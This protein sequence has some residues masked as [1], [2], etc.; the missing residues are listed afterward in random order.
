MEADSLDDAADGLTGGY[1]RVL[2]H[3]ASQQSGILIYKNIFT[4]FALHDVHAVLYP[5]IVLYTMLHTTWVLMY[6]VFMHCVF[7]NIF[8][9][10]VFQKI[11]NFLG[12]YQP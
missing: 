5:T 3:M 1:A 4:Y 7:S 8:H 10:R 9:V 6:Y 12:D 11:L 2:Y